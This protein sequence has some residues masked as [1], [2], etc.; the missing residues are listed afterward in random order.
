MEI[1]VKLFGLGKAQNKVDRMSF[2]REVFS[3]VCSKVFQ[4]HTAGALNQNL[5]LQH[6][7]LRLVCLSRFLEKRKIK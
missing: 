5:N 4:M 1:N 2:C 7:G 3:S 6:T